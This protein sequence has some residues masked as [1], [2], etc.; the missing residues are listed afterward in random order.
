MKAAEQLQRAS[1]GDLLEAGQQLLAP[2]VAI[3]KLIKQ[4]VN[5]PAFQP[6]SEDLDKILTATEN[7]SAL[8]RQT[9]C[10]SCLRSA[11]EMQ[12]IDAT[13]QHDLST[14]IIAIT[15]YSELILEDLE[16]DGDSQSCESLEEVLQHAQKLLNLI[17]ELD[18]LAEMQAISPTL[19][20]RTTTATDFKSSSHPNMIEDVIS[21]MQKSAPSQEQ[22]SLLVVDDKESNRDF[23]SRR[24]I[25]QGFEVEVAKDG[26]QA[27]SMLS[28]QHFDLVLLD[29]IMPELNGYQVLQQ[30]KASDYLKDIPVIMISA[31]DEIDSV[32]KCLEMG[33]E[34]YLQKPFNQIILSTK[35][36]ASLER[37]WLRAREQAHHESLHREQQRTESLLLNILP[38]SI[39]ERLKNG[40]SSIVDS[41]DDVT[42]LF[43][44]IVQFTELSANM[45]P[46]KLVEKLNAIFLAFDHLTESHGLEKIKTI[47]DAYMLVGGMPTPSSDHVHAVASMALQMQQTIAQMNRVD[48]GNIQLRIGI[49]TGPVVA[50]VIGKHKFSYDLWG[51]AVILASRM[52]SQSLPGHIQISETVYQR[53][54]DDFIIDDRGEI[55]IKGRGAMHTYLLTGDK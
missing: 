18:Y 6:F 42:V 48:G 30:L 15:G 19:A 33:A 24:L 13:I 51:D 41:F 20:A 11:S 1:D 21:G 43:A 25:K 44:D 2:S 55:E 14:P 28:K 53:I 27:L 32:V 37:K 39:A 10:R 12:A 9:L 45:A 7:L 46:E 40:E 16:A 3:S 54:K 22:A 49:H 34:D 52:E 38:S 50:G 36:N 26:K 47:G 35:I 8:I 23:L 17:K 4:V 29:I 31:L 5:T